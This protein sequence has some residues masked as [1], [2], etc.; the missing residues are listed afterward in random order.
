MSQR[1]VNQFF[2][3]LVILPCTKEICI[4][5]TCSMHGQRLRH[6]RPG[7]GQGHDCTHL[8]ILYSI[9]YAHSRPK[10]HIYTPYCIV[11][12]K[13]WSRQLV[14]TY[15][16]RNYIVMSY[17]CMHAHPL[18]NR[19]CSK[20][21][22]TNASLYM[23]KR[24]LYN[25]QAMAPIYKFR[26]LTHLSFKTAA[27]GLEVPELL[28]QLMRYAVKSLCKEKYIYTNKATITSM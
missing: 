3:R 22:Y 18:I 21:H 24:Y 2:D 8:H 14:Y 15:C 1:S 12:Q 13:W 4:S 7:V 9:W 28:R 25:W 16:H 5:C 6:Q 10:D 23:G 19:P 17:R 20:W 26:C 11:S 27:S